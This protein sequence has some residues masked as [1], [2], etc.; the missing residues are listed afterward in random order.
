MVHRP[1]ASPPMNRAYYVFFHVSCFG[2]FLI[3]PYFKIRV[4]K[5]L[6][7]TRPT[8]VP[9]RTVPRAVPHA[10][11]P[12]DHLY[13]GQEMSHVVFNKLK[14][15]WSFHQSTKGGDVRTAGQESGVRWRVLLKWKEPKR[16]K[17]QGRNRKLPSQ[18][19]SWSKRL[20]QWYDAVSKNNRGLSSTWRHPQVI[21]SLKLVKNPKTLHK[22]NC[23]KTHLSLLNSIK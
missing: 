3:V 16:A 17:P 19:S 8:C 14:V 1:R 20:F 2:P 6:G 15:I 5:I 13:I 7:P 23:R 9:C 10:A 4:L 18:L 22:T 12:I 21:K 11:R